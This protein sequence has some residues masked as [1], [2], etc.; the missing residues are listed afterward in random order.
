MYTAAPVQDK[1]PQGKSPTAGKPYFY[2]GTTR[3]AQPTRA[4]T[5][6]IRGR[7]LTPGT[8]LKTYIDD[9]PVGETLRV[10]ADGTVHADLPAPAEIG[11]HR[12]VIRRADTGAVVDG[13]MFMVNH[14]DKAESPR[15]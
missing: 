8:A 2:A 11:L 3:G 1:V 5:L 4:R 14:E 6:P 13:M 9:K 12:L 7:D 15:K 10:Q